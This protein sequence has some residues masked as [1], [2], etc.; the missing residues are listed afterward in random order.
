VPENS[1]RRVFRD[2]GID[3]F[4]RAAIVAFYSAAHMLASFW[5]NRKL[6]ARLFRG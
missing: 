2:M 5:F 4:I 6:A 1:K 3:Q